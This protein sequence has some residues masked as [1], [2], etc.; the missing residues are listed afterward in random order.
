M[1]WC[2]RSWFCLALV[3]AL[4]CRA[5]LDEGWRAASE[6][7]SAL[8]RL[9]ANEI[10]SDLPA[11]L[12]PIPGIDEAEVAPID[13]DSASWAD[14]N[15]P[16]AE[17]LSRLAEAGPAA[18]P[19]P[20]PTEAA[21]L[22]A[23]RLY[24]RGMAKR[25]AN[26]N[27]DA[28]ADFTRA[29]R[30]DPGAAAIWLRLAESQAR[31]GEGP[32]SLMSRRR[33]ADLGDQDPVSLYILGSHTSRLGQSEL[34]AHYLARCLL[35][36]PRRVDPVLPAAASLRLADL[37]GGLGYVRGA[38]EAM[39][40]GLTTPLNPR[41][42]SPFLGDLVE[43]RSRS[44]ELWIEMGDLA[45][46]LGETR[47]AQ[48]AYAN[49][50]RDAPDRQGAL[51]A[52]RASVLLSERRHAALALMV[53]DELTERRGVADDRVL[54]LLGVLGEDEAVAPDLARA[55][56][57][58]RSALGGSVPR[59]VEE[60]M[61]L[62]RCAVEPDERALGTARER[63]ALRA[64]EPRVLDALF[65]RI[66]P[67][68]G[69]EAEA[70][71][72]VE[73][74]PGDTAPIAAALSRWHE[75]P[76]ALIESLPEGWAGELLRT[77]LRI[78]FARTAE[79]DAVK[80][81]ASAP[82][83]LV[84]ALGRA[85]GAA[86]SWERVDAALALLEGHPLA[87]ARVCRAAQRLEDAW[88]RVEP[89][90]EGEASYA[91]L[92]LGSELA[93]SGGMAREAQALLLRAV[94]IDPFDERAY[95]GLI[96]VYRAVGDS[97]RLGETI[98]RLRDRLPSANLLRWAEAQDAARRGTLGEAEE[99]LRALAADRPDRDEPVELLAEIWSRHA[100]AG[101]REALADAREWV[102]RRARSRPIAAPL[103]AARARL[104]HL[105]GRVDEA[106]EALRGLHRS[107][108]TPMVR[109]WLEGVLREEGLVSEA[110][111]VAR[112]A[113]RD[114]GPGI[115]PSLAYAESLIRSGRLG[116][117]SGVV[118]GAMPEGVNLTP[119]QAGRIAS[120][121][122]ATLTQMEGRPDGRT[123]RAKLGAVDRA[124]ELGI[125][126]DWRVL[127]ARWAM[128]TDE[129]ETPEA[130]VLRATEDFLGG[131]DSV[132]SARA[133]VSGAVMSDPMPIRTLEEGRGSVAYLLANSLYSSGREGAALEVFALALRHY[134]DHA[135]AAN[136][137]G[138][139]LV[140]RGERLDEAERLLERAYSLKPDQ[141]SIADS[142]GWLRYKLGQME[143][144]ARA[145]GTTEPGAVSLLTR[146]TALP[147][148]QENPTI[149][150]HLG[151]AL[152]RAGQR[153][154]AS[155]SWIRAQQ[156]LVDRLVRLRE[157]GSGVVRRRL[158]EQAERI[159]AK[160]DAL[161]DGE[162]P[163]L[164]PLAGDR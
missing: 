60:S 6:A 22:E 160:V 112:E 16:L 123:R 75:D 88:G 152:W 117:V 109:R 48:E 98:A 103:L 118:L 25:T 119:R 42:R 142:L 111:A 65:V 99:T 101:N 110:D 17:V 162:E 43:A 85:A 28:V 146:A 36:D 77:E 108:P 54:G 81:D 55:L 26:E 83:A 141:A 66:G 97:G 130:E 115:E 139:F 131:L 149:H 148:G 156:L 20:P 113:Y 114:A 86:G 12:P 7:Y 135:W 29:A 96:N 19:P 116:E 31:S 126:L 133:V 134:P 91:T 21:R 121:L 8:E 58:L 150:D 47:R 1:R 72:L 125:P 158:T 87:A 32:A 11:P 104:L 52:R 53:L 78:R 128:L 10:A 124:L 157:P 40:A 9:A 38:M 63:L 106:V 82:P 153:D 30:L 59:S 50:G 140:E 163:P 92:V 62:A 5:Q 15:L 57:D 100:S 33:A 39:E 76:A 46:R 70:I 41:V 69:L 95:E 23:Q 84:E 159:G 64:D 13:R 122:G 147:G 105:D 120:I 132:E 127:W 51:R 94:E 138:Y 2:R 4:T 74:H 136:D 145:D 24:A 67:P 143:D 73:A 14:A 161:R 137:L 107:R 71:S 61:V 102:E 27:A 89:E 151:D 37:L 45:T 164:A 56:G 79:A 129:A 93:L 154:R 3:G 49:A 44:A 144:R 90:L 80:L 34:A 35:A 155:A 18:D 68:G